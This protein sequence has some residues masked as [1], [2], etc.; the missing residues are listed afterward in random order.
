MSQKKIT[1]RSRMPC[2]WLFC[3]WGQFQSLSQTQRSWFNGYLS[4][5]RCECW[6]STTTTGLCRLWWSWRTGNKHWHL[7]VLFPHGCVFVCHHHQYHH[8]QHYLHHHLA[9]RSCVLPTWKKVTRVSF[10]HSSGV[11]LEVYPKHHHYHY[12]RLLH[13]LCHMCSPRYCHP[14]WL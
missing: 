13:L 2:L 10:G 7:R 3:L 12:N 5:C 6:T 9:C 11:T 14:S 4:P 1:Q 8:H